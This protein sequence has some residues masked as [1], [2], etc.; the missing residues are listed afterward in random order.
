MV[1]RVPNKPTFFSPRRSASVRDSTT[2]LINGTGDRARA[3]L[4]TRCG[5]LEANAAKSTP[6]R[7][8]LPKGVEQV[9]DYR[10]QVIGAKQVQ[11]LSVI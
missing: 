10:G 11:H 7:A 1:K 3:S 4:K 8:S 5:V 2:I 6:A 9:I